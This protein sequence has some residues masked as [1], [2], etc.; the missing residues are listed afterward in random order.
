[1]SITSI[2][3]HRQRWA[4]LPP[5]RTWPH[6]LMTDDDAT[7]WGDILYM[8]GLVDDI[9]DTCAID[10]ARIPATARELRGDYSIEFD[11]DLYLDP[12]PNDVAGLLINSWK[13][14]A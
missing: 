5:L 8:R 9:E 6:E 1:M 3:A 2:E 12:W 4:A 11:I 7:A 10:G 13:A 14:A